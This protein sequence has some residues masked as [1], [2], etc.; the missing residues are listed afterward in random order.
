MDARQMWADFH[1]LNVTIQDVLSDPVQSWITRALVRVTY[2]RSAA[3]SAHGVEQLC[4]IKLGYD[5]PF[6]LT[7]VLHAGTMQ[8]YAE[9]WT[10]LLQLRRGKAALDKILV[11]G[12]EDGLKGL[13]ALRSR[14]AWFIR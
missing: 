1:F 9:V 11:R 10:F 6:P 4:G 12:V 8:A 14:L 3:P 2:S 13:W 7:Y 5:V